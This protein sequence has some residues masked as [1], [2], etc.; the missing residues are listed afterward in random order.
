MIYLPLSAWVGFGVM[1]YVP[2]TLHINYSITPFLP[3]MTKKTV[4]AVSALTH[5]MVCDKT[6]VDLPPGESAVSPISH[7]TKMCMARTN[8]LR[9]LCYSFGDNV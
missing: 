8:N 7:F 3:L 4:K 9:Y 1:R 6:A 2:N 5:K